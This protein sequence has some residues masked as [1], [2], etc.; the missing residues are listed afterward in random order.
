MSGPLDRLG[1]RL[2]LWLTRRNM[3]MRG[4]G[5]AS[6]LR[7]LDVARASARR[8]GEILVTDGVLDEVDDVMY[9]T[10]DEIGGEI[11]ADARSLV[12]ERRAEQARYRSFE[13][14]TMFWGEPVPVAAAP[15][16]SVPAV[17]TLTG[18]GASAGV[19]EGVARVVT[20]PSFTEVEPGEVLIAATTDPSWASVMLV[21][22]ALVVDIGGTLSH[23]AVVARELGIPCVVNTGTGTTSLCTGDRVR[24][25]GTAG[26]VT[27][28]ERIC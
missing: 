10:A 23:A 26:T 18:I 4:I 13:I 14:P 22:A 27:V 1:A 9:L 3:P 5:K 25:D 19:V 12:A 8:I 16:D 11:P 20:D 28:L 7:S 17:S 6:F 24:V 21:S 2:V 15:I